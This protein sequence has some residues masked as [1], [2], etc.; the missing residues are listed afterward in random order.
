MAL[1]GR[2]NWWLPRWLDRALPTV[3]VEE[4]PS[5]AGA[6]GTAGAQAAAEPAPV[7]R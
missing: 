1:L 4:E 5:G 3:S 6:A 7:G 2:S